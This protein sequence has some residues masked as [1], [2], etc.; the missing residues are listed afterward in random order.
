M[1]LRKL[2]YP[3]S[4]VYGGIT[5]LRNQLFDAGILRAKSYNIP[6]ISVGNITVGGTGKTPLTEY[7]I[8]LL[9]Y[10]YK[11]CLL[12][13]GYK[14]QTKGALLADSASTAETIGDE[15]F[16]VLSK[17]PDINVVVAE[18]RVEGMELILHQ[19]NTELVLMDDAYQHRYVK[20]GLSILVIDYNRP[21]WK[22]C[23]FPAGNLRET[24]KG[25]VRAD[26]IVVNKC[27][28]NFSDDER[29]FWLRN[30]KITSAQEVYFTSIRYGK[31]QA[32]LNK[33]VSDPFAAD[34]VVAL[35][36]IAQ[37][38]G[39][40]HHLSKRFQVVEQLIYPDHHHFTS[41]DITQIAATLNKPGRVLLTTE[42]DAVRLNAFPDGIKKKCWFVPIELKVLFNEEKQFENRIR[43][44]VRNHSNNG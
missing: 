44:Y 29:A 30:L 22:D 2:L 21:L 36:G 12:S 39:F 33:P 13:R 31:E 3:F 43:N 32:L 14:R 7:L 6:L 11:M 20:P 42:K 15:P 1:K 34:E 25:Q 17:F 37:P 28:L 23:P 4:I 35:A 27:P 5:T 38:S 18:K 9:K 19:T 41:S 24:R 8:R 40:L 26:V 10:D 16:Q